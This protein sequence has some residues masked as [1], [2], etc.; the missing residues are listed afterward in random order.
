MPELGENSDLLRLVEQCLAGNSLAVRD[1]V[2]KYQ[3]PIFGLCYRMLTH[4][5][6]AED[7][8]QETLVRAIRALH[9]WDRTRD[10]LPWLF[11]IA[12]NRCRSLLTKRKNRSVREL[13]IEQVAAEPDREDAARNLGEELDRSLALVR[14]EFRQAFLLFHEQELSYAQIGEILDCPLGTVKT[15]IHRARKEIIED[16]RKR[17]VLTEANYAVRRV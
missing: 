12:G 7:M 6:D 1:F 15:W 14:P 2:S 16:L 10:I 9:Q 3:G 17:D 11:S 4:R 13:P 8:T 5:Q